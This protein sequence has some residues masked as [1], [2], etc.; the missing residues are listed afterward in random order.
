MQK[1]FKKILQRGRIDGQQHVQHP[2]LQDTV[3]AIEVRS[4]LDGITYS[5][6]DNHLTAAVSD[7]P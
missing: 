2:H 6:A 1:M 5:E 7:I 4:D 3:K